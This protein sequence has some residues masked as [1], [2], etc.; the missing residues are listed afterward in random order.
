MTEQLSLEEAMD[1]S[2]AELEALDAFRKTHKDEVDNLLH[3]ATEVLICVLTGMTLK[4]PT[5]ML[6]SREIADITTLAIIYGYMKG[7]QR[8]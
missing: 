1:Y 4:T 5:I 6:L 3:N 7:L 8:V 2:H